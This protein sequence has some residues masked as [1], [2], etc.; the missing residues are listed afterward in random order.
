MTRHRRAA[1]ALGALIAGIVALSGCSTGP[2]RASIEG[3]RGH[4]IILQ[5]HALAYCADAGLERWTASVTRVIVAVHGIDRNACG[6]LTAVTS[7]L[8]ITAGEGDTAV[9]APLFATSADA[10]P[11]GHAWDP[12]GWPAGEPAD[13]GVSSYAVMDALVE[14]L[15]PREITLV[16]FSAGGQLVNRYAS[17]SPH[18]LHRYVVVN[19]SSYLWFT[20]DRPIGVGPCP[21]VNA[22]RY[23]LDERQGYPAQSDAATLRARYGARTVHYLIGAADD[24]PR[25]T[26]MDRSCAAMAQGANR[27][28]RALHYH[29]HLIEV[30]GPSIEAQ[31][32]L[33]VVSGIGHNVAAMLA[34]PEGR[35]ALR[36]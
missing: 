15:G 25:S 11:G 12:R 23:G 7:A 36:G 35:E 13:T 2:P 19:P 5:G 14:A 27:E 10:T 24:D 20:P 30:F 16:G 8:G 28:A 32:P 31:Q 18:T 6:M 22:W 34:S 17:A 3:R 33:H 21:G 26:S 29:R 1:R 9:I 4:T